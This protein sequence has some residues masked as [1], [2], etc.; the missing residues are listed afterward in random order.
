[1][2]NRS[3]ALM[4]GIFVLVLGA[5]AVA[6]IWWFSTGGENT[7][8]FVVVSQRSVTGLN[9]QAAVRFRGVRVGKVTAI[10]LQHQGEVRIQ[11]RVAA[12]T[13]VTRGTRARI[14]MAGITGQGY[15]QLEDDNSDP[16]PLS[17]AGA[18]EP[19]RI[20]LQPG[21]MDDLAEAGRDVLGRLRESTARIERI[22]SDENLGHINKT[23]A[24]LATSSEHL[25]RTLEQTA[26]LAADVRRFASP[27]NAA[28]LN[29]TLAQV[30]AASAQ[31]APAVEDF[32]KTLARVDAAAGRIDRL[33]ADVQTGLTGETLPRINQLAADLQLST[34]QLGRV[35]DDLQRAPQS[36]LMGKRAPVLG[37]GESMLVKP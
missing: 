26:A 36:M 31:L 15:V 27:D 8:Q 34:Q 17:A 32:R 33:G 29:A 21:L 13:P 16:A 9:P 5:C 24:Q 22:L 23:L 6:V 7:R 19:P 20:A 28:H 37:P 2:E 1:M 25:Q 3:Y 10:D 12:D 14:G 11:I 18:G 30:R 35:L 4:V